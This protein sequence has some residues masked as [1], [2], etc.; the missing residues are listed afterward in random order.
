MIDLTCSSY[1][2]FLFFFLMIRRPPRSTL[3]PYTTL[4][5]SLADPLVRLREAI[6]H[7]DVAHVAGPCDRDAMLALHAGGRAGEHERA[8]AERDRLRDVVRDEDDGLPPQVPE[9]QEVGL[10]L[11]ARLRVQRAE[12]L[13]H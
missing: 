9:A 2:C 3:F 12:R 1:D 13:V 5:R 6:H 8:V 7:V 11:R 10:Q 4:F